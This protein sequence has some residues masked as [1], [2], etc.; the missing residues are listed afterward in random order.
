MFMQSDEYT[1]TNVE[2]TEVAD[3][4]YQFEHK[5]NGISVTVRINRPSEEAIEGFNGR[6]HLSNVRGNSNE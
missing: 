2:L 3:D 6:V 1:N 5:I 4:L